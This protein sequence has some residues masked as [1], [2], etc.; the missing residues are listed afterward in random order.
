MWQSSNLGDVI[1]SQKPWTGLGRYTLSESW[2]DVAQSR[3]LKTIRAELIDPTP[4]G[5]G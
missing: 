4:S 5:M 2:A 1:F 3:R